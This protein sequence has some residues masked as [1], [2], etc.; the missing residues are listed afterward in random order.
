MTSRTYLLG[1]M[2][3]MGMLALGSTTSPNGCPPNAIAVPAGF[4]PATASNAQLAKYGFMQKPYPDRAVQPSWWVQAMA[5]SR[6]FLP[7]GSHPVPGASDPPPPKP[8]A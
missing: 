6:C 1:G 7:P 8:G 5:H 4:N 3:L 2:L